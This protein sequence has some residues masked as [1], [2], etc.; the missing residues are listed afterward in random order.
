MFKKIEAYVET[1]E[2]KVQ[3]WNTLKITKWKSH[4]WKNTKIKNYM[5][6]TNHRLEKAEHRINELEDRSME[7][8][9]TEELKEK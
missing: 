9:W 2:E 6:K 8:S 4:N 3:I 7:N 5:T 1:R